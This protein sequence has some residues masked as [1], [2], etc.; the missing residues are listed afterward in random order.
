MEPA[1]IANLCRLFFFPSLYYLIVLVV[2][3]PLLSSVQKNR[4]QEH[5]IT[6]VWLISSE[7]V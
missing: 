6:D 4:K 3:Q 7:A 5:A 2:L 1:R